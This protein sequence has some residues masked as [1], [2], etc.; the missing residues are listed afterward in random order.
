MEQTDILVIGGG[1]AGL[2]FAIE[3]A[4][5]LPD[6]Q[7][8]I[9]TKGK[10]RS[11]NTYFAQGGIAAVWDLQYDTFDKH[12]T[13]TM[14]A[15]AGLCV[16]EVVESVVKEGP[17]A[18]NQLISW[19]VQFDKNRN[20]E[21][22]LHREGGHCV[23]RILH[24]KDSTGASLLERLINK[25]QS[26]PNI[27][28]KEGFM[29]IDLILKPGANE[30]KKSTC[31]GAFF[32]DENEEII[33]RIYAQTIMLATGGAGQ[34]YQNTTNPHLATGD[35]VAMAYRAGASVA[36]MEF[37]QFHPTALYDPGSNPSFLITEALRGAGAV[38][39]DHA[40]KEFMSK[41]DVRGSLAPRDIV[42]RALQTEIENSGKEYML[43]D[44]SRVGE[45]RFI[46]D[47]PTVFNKCISI[48]INPLKDP[49]PVVPAAHYFC[50]G[51]KV[52]ENGQTNIANLFAGGECA[53]TGLHGANRLA[54][55]SLLEALV[56][57]SRSSRAIRKLD[58]SRYAKGEGVIW[59]SRAS[60]NPSNNAN[61]ERYKEKIKSLMTANANIVRNMPELFKL[62][63]ELKLILDEL[64]MLRFVG[65]LSPD[66]CEVNNMATVAMLVA[67]S[68]FRRNASVGLHFI[69]KMTI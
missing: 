22:S 7:V 50:G 19:G 3:S 62:M 40:G 28:I 15:G 34:I 69:K 16:R 29:G 24:I 9:V 30:Y 31:V 12:I 13:D 66:L 68:A 52:D 42:A 14:I 11:S 27:E 45:Q 32:F 53:Y 44:T 39:I 51:I 21:F 26:L 49:I 8:L 65:P 61:L 55:N 35:G 25:A 17:A 58:L 5:A 60:F 57:A 46:F 43:L 38:L 36:N 23:D 67:K 63:K 47:F 54:S 18:I 20:G 48:G 33:T 1:I 41:Y 4:L 56:F 64:D 59:Y 10:I 2:S 37:V 6:K